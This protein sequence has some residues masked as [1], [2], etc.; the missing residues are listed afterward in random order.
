[1][2]TTGGWASMNMGS[3]V[4]MALLIAALGWLKL[5]HHNRRDQNS[6]L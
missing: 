4:P 2:V 5:G 6:A 1:L 3:L